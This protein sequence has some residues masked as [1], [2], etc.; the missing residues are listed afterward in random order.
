MCR[1]STSS[2]VFR[3]TDKRETRRSPLLNF[4]YLAR[5]G[6]LKVDEYM[7]F[8]FTLSWSASIDLAST[9]Q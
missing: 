2:M 6:R 3:A 1:E 9:R 8:P 4:L 5:P 7:R